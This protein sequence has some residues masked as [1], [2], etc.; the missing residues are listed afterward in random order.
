MKTQLL[1]AA[2]LLISAKYRQAITLTTA[3]MYVSKVSV[4]NEQVLA[5]RNIPMGRR[6]HNT[7]SG[8]HW[9]NIEWGKINCKNIYRM[10][11]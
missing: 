8:A 9:N 3:A 7:V 1:T 2:L 6:H 10:A 5:T 4:F 11:L